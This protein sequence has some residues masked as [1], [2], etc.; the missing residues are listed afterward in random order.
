[1]LPSNLKRVKA[2]LYQVFG[3]FTFTSRSFP[4][5]D[6]PRIPKVK[7]DLCIR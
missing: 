2:G 3:C 7:E 6:L 5:Y 4:V 1:M